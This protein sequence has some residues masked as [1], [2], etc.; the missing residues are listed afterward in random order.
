VDAARALAAVQA[1]TAGIAR[2]RVTIRA[3]LD[4]A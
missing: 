2:A 3:I 4:M 1:V